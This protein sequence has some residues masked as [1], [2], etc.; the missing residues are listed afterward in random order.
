MA[1]MVDASIKT[2]PMIPELDLNIFLPN[3]PRIINPR[4]G[5]KGI[6]N[7]IVDDGIFIYKRIS[8]V[9]H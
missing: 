7:M 3:N 6:N 4:K 9:E 5:S 2:V 8:N 1:M